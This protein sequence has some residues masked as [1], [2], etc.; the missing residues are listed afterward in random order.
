[1]IDRI[2]DIKE[3]VIERLE[4][5]LDERGGDR[6]DIQEVGKLADIVK[7]LAEAEKCC[8]ER[9]YYESVTDAMES[10]GYQMDGMGYP[11]GYA[12]QGGS[13]GGSGGQSRG[14]S[15]GGSGGRSGYRDSMGRYARRGYGYDPMQGIRDAMMS[16]DPQ[17]RERMQGELRQMLGM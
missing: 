17:E 11:M 12:Q 5:S 7:D 10:S 8:T 13:R 9:D 15:R 2:Y 14:G 6:M 16:A 1:M 3:K 4:K